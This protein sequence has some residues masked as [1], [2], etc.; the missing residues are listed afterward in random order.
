[1]SDM[2]ATCAHSS[3]K[4]L[5]RSPRDVFLVM[6]SAREIHSIALDEIQDKNVAPFESQNEKSKSNEFV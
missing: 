6:H 3:Q 4:L 1:M 5:A 2:A